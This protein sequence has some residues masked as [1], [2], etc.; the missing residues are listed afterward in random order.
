MSAAGE[1]EI[2]RLNKQQELANAIREGLRLLARLQE[3]ASANDDS[4]MLSDNSDSDSDSNSDTD[5]LTEHINEKLRERKERRKRRR[6]AFFGS[7]AS[8]TR[9]NDP[10][11]TRT[12]RHT[13]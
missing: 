13:M 10:V 3:T 2:K 4:G 9:S 1:K 12:R 8:R 5:W 7:V 6:I 11:A